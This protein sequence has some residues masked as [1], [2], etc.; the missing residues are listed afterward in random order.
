M[1]NH[2]NDL[3]RMP[4]KE[5]SNNSSNSSYSPYAFP[6]ELKSAHSSGQFQ[7]FPLF[8]NLAQLDK[9]CYSRRQGWLCLCRFSDRSVS[10]CRRDAKTSHERLHD[11][12]QK[13]QARGICCQPND[14]YRRDQQDSQQGV[15][16]HGHCEPLLAYM[17]SFLIGVCICTDYM[18][19]PTTVSKAVLSGS[20][21]ASQRHFQLKIPRLRLSSS[22]KQLSQE[23]KERHRRPVYGRPR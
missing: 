6:S 8:S 22:P 17:N 16:R 13:T 1:D 10:K 7:F 12:R 4:L 19:P 21:Q 2:S 20:S 11:F 5:P 9:L 23:K 3:L 15:E 14:A 18:L